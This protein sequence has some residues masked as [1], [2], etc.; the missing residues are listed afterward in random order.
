MEQQYQK[1][2]YVLFWAWL[3]LFVAAMFFFLFG[4]RYFPVIGA[5][6]NL[7]ILMLA[8]LDVL[9]ALMLITQSVYWLGGV[10]YEAAAK[11]GTEAR[12]RYAF[13]NLVIFLAATALFLFY[14]FGM[15]NLLRPD[16]TRDSLVAGG[17]VCAAAMVSSRLRL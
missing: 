17:V 16:A 14:C 6:K 12:R 15:K 10:S 2:S 3:T 7:G 4:R 5:G 13:R 9:F 8:F 11:A 1:K